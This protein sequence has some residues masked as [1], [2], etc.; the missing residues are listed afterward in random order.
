MS[1]C[2]VNLGKSSNF[3]EPVCLLANNE[4][5]FYLLYIMSSKKTNQLTLSASYRKIKK[6][7]GL[8]EDL[9]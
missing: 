8:K 6:F 4:Q 7:E 2:Y 1:V 3:S 5:K 9:Y